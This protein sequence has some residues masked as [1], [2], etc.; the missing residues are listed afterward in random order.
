MIVRIEIKGID[1]DHLDIDIH[2]EE[3]GGVRGEPGMEITKDAFNALV[4]QAFD[5]GC[6]SFKTLD[7]MTRL[8][9]E[10]GEEAE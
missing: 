2:H 3:D 10:Q 6:L 1:D 8:N 4:R 7:H 9:W 5:M